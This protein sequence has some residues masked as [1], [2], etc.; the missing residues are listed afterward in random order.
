MIVANCNPTTRL[1]GIEINL[2][3][4]CASL[5]TLKPLVSK[6]LS[7]QPNSNPAHSKGHTFVSPRRVVPE[8]GS[9]H[10]E[11]LALRENDDARSRWS[12]ESVNRDQ[13]IL[14]TR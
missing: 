4:I 2:G 13:S 9:L 7:R 6:S 12:V 14:T 1:A 3:I 11:E 5:P 8:K 10:T